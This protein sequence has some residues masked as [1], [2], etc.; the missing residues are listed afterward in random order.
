MN[1]SV[2]N[3]MK[4]TL[5]WIRKVCCCLCLWQLDYW[6]KWHKKILMKKYE[7]C[8][9]MICRIFIRNVQC[10]STL[11][12]IFHNVYNKQGYTSSFTHDCSYLDMLF[13]RWASREGGPQAWRPAMWPWPKTWPRSC[14]PRSISIPPNPPPPPPWL[15]S[16]RKCH[17]PK[18]KH[19]L[20]TIS[21]LM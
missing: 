20:Y 2:L 13:G 5:K 3:F 19:F 6:T 4:L 9:F 11:L 18:S 15:K 8:E 10:S 16:H 1:M 7:N 21:V 14:P 12:S 17:A